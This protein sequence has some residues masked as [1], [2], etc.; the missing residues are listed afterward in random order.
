[1]SNFD[2]LENAI[3]EIDTEVKKLISNPRFIESLETIQEKLEQFKYLGELQGADLMK[4]R[5]A[6]IDF[7]KMTDVLEVY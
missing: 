2:N 4:L 3:N 5:R 1:M 7:I 6:M